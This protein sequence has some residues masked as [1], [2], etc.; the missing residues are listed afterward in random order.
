MIAMNNRKKMAAEQKS[1][2]IYRNKNNN[3][4]KNASIP[5]T[6]EEDP[7]SSQGVSSHRI[8]AH[9]NNRPISERAN[10]GS[11]ERD[12]NECVCKGERTRAE[13]TMC[14]YNSKNNCR[15]KR[16]NNMINTEQQ[17]VCRTRQLT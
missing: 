8:P 3:K 4:N 5:E 12:H 7:S 2:G 13:E 11:S 10:P 1:K 9:Q 17:P 16:L 14:I 6:K 15:Y